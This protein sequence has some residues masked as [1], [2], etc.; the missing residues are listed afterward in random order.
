MKL[1]TIIISLLPIVSYSQSYDTTKVEYV[2]Y[3]TRLQDSTILHGDFTLFHDH[4]HF[5]M[6]YKS[7]LIHNFHARLYAKSN[8]ILIYM[9]N[10]NSFLEIGKY[11]LKIFTEESSIIYL[12]YD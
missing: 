7:N 12:R 11:H 3:Q 5:R 8:G 10:P 1:L 4:S 9:I 2:H 6:T